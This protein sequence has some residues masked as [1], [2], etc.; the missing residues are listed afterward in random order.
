MLHPPHGQ[1]SNVYVASTQSLARGRLG[2]AR[3][4]RRP[5]VPGGM[6]DRRAA[7]IAAESG[8]LGFHYL[9]DTVVVG[10]KVALGEIQ[11]GFRV[12]RD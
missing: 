12:T 8:A 9:L 10:A 2:R 7:C 3:D 11:H 1:R 5:K 4:G 6:A